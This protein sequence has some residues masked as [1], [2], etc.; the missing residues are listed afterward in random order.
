MIREFKQSDIDSIIDIWLNAS[1]KAHDFIK[2]DFWESKTNE[3][4][5]IYIP[6]AENY[7]YEEEGIIKG[8]VSLYEDTIAALFVLPEVQ[9][10][11]IGT[12]LMQK[13]KE[14]RKDLNLTVY[15]ANAKSIKFY[16]G[17]GFKIIKEQTDE[18][19]GCL[20]LLM[21]YNS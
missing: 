3:M 8:F 1:I 7:I 16:I 19:T 9:G 15:K 17:C 11:G 14:M 4:R 12:S 10:L 20:E 21:K 5:E 2:K 6:A 13:A 18:N